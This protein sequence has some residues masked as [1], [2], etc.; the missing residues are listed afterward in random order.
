MDFCT[1]DF[2]K[3]FLFFNV[4]EI[5]FFFPNYIFLNTI[6]KDFFFGGDVDHFL[7]LYWICYNIVSA[8]CSTFLVMRHVE[9]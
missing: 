3:Y 8:L 5:H 2:L 6:L 4:P 7:T 1:I 9:S